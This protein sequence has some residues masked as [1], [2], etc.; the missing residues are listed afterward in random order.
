MTVRG[1]HAHIMRKIINH[2]LGGTFL[3][4][5]WDECD[6]DAITLYEVRNHEHSRSIPCDD[7]MAQH[8][9]YAFCSERHRQYYLACTGKMALETQERN[10]GR[11]GGMLPP[12]YRNRDGGI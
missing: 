11:V 1:T 12:G 9:T 8:C 6:R 10:R 3:C 7:P 5:F 2:D 4:C